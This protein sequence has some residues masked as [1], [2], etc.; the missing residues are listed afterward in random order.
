[1]FVITSL[2]RPARA[3]SWPRPEDPAG[4]GED[5]DADDAAGDHY[6]R[7]DQSRLAA[8]SA[9]GRGHDRGLALQRGSRTKGPRL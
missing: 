9:A 1:L 2:M 5:A 7:I 6:D 4:V 8:K 3:I